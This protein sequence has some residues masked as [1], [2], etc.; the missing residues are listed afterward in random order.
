MGDN[1]YKVSWKNKVEN[2][3]SNVNEV[4]DIENLR[5][6]IAEKTSYDLCLEQPPK[7]SSLNSLSDNNTELVFLTPKFVGFNQLLST[8]LHVIKKQSFKPVKLFALNIELS[9]VSEKTNDDKSF[10]TFE[11]SLNKAKELAVSVL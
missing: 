6:T 3:E 9:A 5:N 7:M 10:F 11:L 2:N 4:L 1:N 8:E